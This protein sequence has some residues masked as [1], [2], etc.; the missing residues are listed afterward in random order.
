M[1]QRLSNEVV[2][3]CNGFSSSTSMAT[4]MQ[5]WRTPVRSPAG[6]KTSRRPRTSS[7]R[8]G[9]G[10]ARCW[11]QQRIDSGL[12]RIGVDV[13][14]D[15]FAV[16]LGDAHVRDVGLAL[17]TRE[18][19]VELS[20]H[21]GFHSGRAMHI[22]WMKAG[23]LGDDVDDGL[24]CAAGFDGRLGATTG[25]LQSHQADE[26]PRDDTDAGTL[27][28]GPHRRAPLPPSRSRNSERNRRLTRI[29]CDT[30]GHDDKSS[31]AAKVT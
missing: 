29:Y 19:P 14:L 25:Q 12:A 2:P 31:W 17:G 18:V 6:S 26:H 13:E 1:S 30:T 20:A 3:R 8:C 16:H 27:D 7:S 10:A 11:P 24:R 4:W 22:G 9:P 21:L 5:V 28:E 15:P 23:L